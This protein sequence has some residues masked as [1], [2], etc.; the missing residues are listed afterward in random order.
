MSSS[1]YVLPR[2]SGSRKKAQIAARRAVANQKN[3]VLPFKLA[4]VGL[5]RYGSMILAMICVMLYMFRD[6]Q[7]DLARSRK[8]DVSEIMV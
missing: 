8:L 1:S 7:T 3:A 4:S 6:R 5:I 2:H